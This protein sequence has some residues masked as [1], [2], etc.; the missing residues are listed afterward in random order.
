MAEVDRLRALSDHPLIGQT[1]HLDGRVVKVLD[2]KWADSVIRDG[3]Q[4][5]PGIKFKVRYVSQKP[6]EKAFWT[7]T[8][9]EK[10]IERGR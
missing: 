5:W 9:P 6:G 8:F 10:E 1:V 4:E 3:K 7:V 2:A